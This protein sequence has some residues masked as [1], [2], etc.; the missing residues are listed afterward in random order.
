MKI[1]VTGCAGFIGF[2]LCNLLLKEKNILIYGVD[3]LNSYYSVEYKK[4]RLEILRKNKRFVFKKIDLSNFKKL[5]IIFKKNKFDLVIN[6]AAQAGVRYAITNPSEYVK[7]NINGF[8]NIIE[9]SRLYKIKK[10]VYASSSSVYG[11]KKTFPLKEDMG[12]EPKNI[13]SLSKKN[14]EDMAKVYSTYYDMH[15]IGLRFFTIYG[16]WGRPDMLILKYIISKF[17]NKKFYLYNYGDHYR[18]FTYVG[19][20]V[21]SIKLLMSKKLKNKHEIFNICSN[22][23]VSLSKILK[24]LND[25]FGSPKIVKRKKDKADVYKTHGSNDKIKKALKIKNLTKFDDGIKLVISWIKNN[26]KL[27]K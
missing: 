16:E 9:L 10:I 4:K 3:N 24:K 8:F 27:F 19:D 22:N 13:Y 26:S 6:L 7:S 14:N 5:E 25:N 21:K 1:L 11:E 20:A 17:R 15:F 18:D 2:H 12:L 23:P